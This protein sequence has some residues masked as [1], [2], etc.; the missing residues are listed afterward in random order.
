M[1]RTFLG[2]GNRLCKGLA[3]MDGGT[4]TLGLVG[5]RELKQVP[6]GR[7]LGDGSWTWV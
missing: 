1:E 6:E 3:V 5:V 4:E 7:G 2:R